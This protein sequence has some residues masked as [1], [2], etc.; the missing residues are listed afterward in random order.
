MK[1]F[2]LNILPELINGKSY[3]AISEIPKPFQKDI[4]N[5]ISGETIRLTEKG[6]IRIGDNMYKSWIKKLI[7]K[8][9]DYE[10]DLKL[11]D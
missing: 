6:E 1:I 5:F 7:K 10:V 2:N 11:N 9:F 4:L 8:G 3:L